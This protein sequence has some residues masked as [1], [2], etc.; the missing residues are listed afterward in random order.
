ML[1]RLYGPGDPFVFHGSLK[2]FGESVQRGEQIVDPNLQAV[3]SSVAR[4]KVETYIEM[5][6]KFSIY[7]VQNWLLLLQLCQFF[8]TRKVLLV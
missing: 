3:G 7:L 4:M 6:H 5:E 1:T 2:T 8:S